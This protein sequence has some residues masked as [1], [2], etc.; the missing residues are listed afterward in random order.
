MN[1]L[2]DE[3]TNFTLDD[4][5]MYIDNGLISVDTTDDD[6]LSTSLDISKYL[7]KR[8]E[9]GLPLTPI[10]EDDEFIA[11][12]SINDVTIYNCK[13]YNS[14]QKIV[15]TVLGCEFASYYDK[16]RIYFINTLI[17]NNKKFLLVHSDIAWASKII[18][19]IIPSIKLPYFPEKD[20][21]I[22][23]VE[24]F[25]YSRI[26]SREIINTPDF[27]YAVKLSYVEHAGNKYPIDRYYKAV[28][29]PPHTIDKVSKEYV[30]ISNV[31]YEQLVSKRWTTRSY[32]ATI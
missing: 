24:E 28:L 18:D 1:N 32:N 27:L 8:I 11:D 15:S 21:A 30:E 13:R 29:K 3:I 14:L 7:I 16:N 9:K 20:Q 22:L 4:L 17:D 19:D 26:K 25:V 5:K 10:T 6:I 31:E 2:S 23:Y 12:F